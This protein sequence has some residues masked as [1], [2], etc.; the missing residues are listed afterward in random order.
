MDSIII[1]VNLVGQISG[2]VKHTN[3]QKWTAQLPAKH[4]GPIS[5]VIKHTDRLTTE[6]TRASTV[7]GEYVESWTT[8]EAPVWEKASVWKKMTKVQRVISHVLRFDEGY[9]VSFEFLGD[10]DE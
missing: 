3:R 7:P 5:K 8:G 2:V 1:K 4:G 6:C 10:G 9:G